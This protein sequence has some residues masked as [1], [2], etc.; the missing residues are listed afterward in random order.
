MNCPSSPDAERRS[1]LDKLRELL[2][3]DNERW[4]ALLNDTRT[5]PKLEAFVRESREQGKAPL[6]LDRL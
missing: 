2:S 1:I 5:R 4:E 6:D 3:I